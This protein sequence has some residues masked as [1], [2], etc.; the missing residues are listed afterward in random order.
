MCIGQLIQKAISP[1]IVN[2]LVCVLI[3]SNLKANGS[4]ENMDTAI[5][6][7]ENRQTSWAEKQLSKDGTALDSDDK[8]A[9]ITGFKEALNELKL[10]ILAF[11]ERSGRSTFLVTYSLS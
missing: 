9:E 8:K 7:M 5:E 1:V 10:A 4:C 11:A 3:I 2:E 6:T